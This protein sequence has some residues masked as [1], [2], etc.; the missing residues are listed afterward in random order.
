M[1]SEQ[2]FQSSHLV[3]HTRDSLLCMYLLKCPHRRHATQEVF[4]TATIF[5]KGK[6]R[7]GQG[8]TQGPSVSEW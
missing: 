5:Q 1:T 7:L 3:P 2:T 6:L 8:T 4:E